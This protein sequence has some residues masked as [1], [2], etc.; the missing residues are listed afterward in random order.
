METD[1]LDIPDFLESKGVTT[2]VRLS[3]FS[4]DRESRWDTGTF[5]T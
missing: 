4:S 1:E 5:E 2:D 3:F